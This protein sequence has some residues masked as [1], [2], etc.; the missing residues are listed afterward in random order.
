LT[1]DATTQLIQRIMGQL[2]STDASVQS[3]KTDFLSE[4]DSFIGNAADYAQLIGTISGPIVAADVAASI[5]AARAAATAAGTSA[6]IAVDAAGVAGASGQVEVAAVVLAIAAVLAI[7]SSLGGSTDDTQQQLQQVQETLVEIE[8]GVIAGYWT[9]ITANIGNYV[10][11][12]QTDLDLIAGE[13]LFGA[14]VKGSATVNGFI[15]HA[16]TYVNALVPGKTLDAGLIYWQRPYVKSAEFAAQNILVWES[17]PPSNL[18]LP[19][20]YGKIPNLP[21]GSS[22]VSGESYNTVPDPRS[23]LPYLSWGF[24][25]YLTIWELASLIDSTQPSFGQFLHDFQSSEL[26]PYAEWFLSQAKMAIRGLRMSDLPGTEDIVSYAWWKADWVGRGSFPDNTQY[27]GGSPPPPPGGYSEQGYMWNGVYGVFD[28]YSV[29][30]S[31]VGVPS[32]S[33]SHLVDIISGTPVY[34][35]DGNVHGT[36]DTSAIVEEFENAFGGPSPDTYLQ[37]AALADWV[38][39]WIQDKLILGLMARWKALY[40]I[41]GYDH[42]WAVAQNLWL[43]ANPHD[44]LSPIRIQLPYPPEWVSWDQDNPN[45][46][47][48]FV[49]SGNWSAR[50]LCTLLN[51]SGDVLDGVQN[52]DLT[53]IVGP[54]Q[55]SGSYETVGGP[56]IGGYSLF[57]LV[58]CLDNIASGNWGG[59]PSYSG[60][61]NDAPPTG[62]GPAR[63]IGFRNRLAA[64][65]V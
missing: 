39:P 19:G 21:V 48:S 59:P 34:D 40:L 51:L 15:S 14:G 5:Q 11:S 50:E 32:A 16:T 3:S 47:S 12:V 36:N 30:L 43:I 42:V 29:Y 57:A 61:L 9:I 27:W 65:A 52:G 31:P 64:A 24:T 44:S 1:E 49:A 53:T 8:N 17:G 26:Q 20:W 54:Y 22:I 35:A 6:D 45:Q 63:P 28:E 41:N 37:D 7:V 62:N 60:N 10:A 4:L 58:Q 56:V 33:P 13:G 55:E 46:N 18:G 23:M 2:D 38:A 25:S